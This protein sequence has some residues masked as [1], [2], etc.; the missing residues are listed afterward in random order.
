MQKIK[1]QQQYKDRLFRMAF[2]EKEHLLALYNA[3]NGS[4]YDNP[5]DLEIRTLEDVIYIGIKND[6]SFVL[7]FVLNL[8]EHQ[9]SFNPNMPVRGLGYFSRMYQ[10]Y[11]EENEINVYGSRL[12]PL[13][14]PQYIVFYNG[15]RKEPDRVELRLSDA[16]VRS[17]SISADRQPCLEVRALMLNINWGH[18]RE[19]MEQCQRL[20]EYSQCIAIIREYEAKF[21]GR[22]D[23]VAKAVDRC[24]REGLLADI[25]SGNKA[26]VIA[27]FLTE[28]DEQKH[29]RLERKEAWSEGRSEGREEGKYLTILHQVRKKVQK[30]ISAEKTAEMLEE[31]VDLIEQIYQELISRPDQTDKE[32]LSRIWN[33]PDNEAEDEI[34]DGWW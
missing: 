9:G 25:L 19:L 17:E 5:D 12:Q 31:P 1:V 8:Y 24:I 23:A 16:F 33:V 6:V 20:K 21:T 14:F 7:D 2:R 13:P 26:E 4:N 22:E 27:M 28:Y 30:G 11:I 10:R 32:I 15:T 18:N 34:I 29:I 3:I